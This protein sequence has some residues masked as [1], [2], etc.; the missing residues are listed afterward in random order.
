M[1]WEKVKSALD[2]L[3][4]KLDAQMCSGVAAMDATRADNIGDSM[5]H[6]QQMAEKHAAKKEEYRGA[7]QYDTLKAHDRAEGLHY[8]AA[9]LYKQ[10]RQN[11]MGQQEANKAAERANSASARLG[12]TRADAVG[13]A[14]MDASRD[15]KYD[16]GRTERT[17][18]IKKERKEFE[19]T[20]VQFS[21]GERVRFVNKGITQA[22][23]SGEQLSG[24]IT[25]IR[26]SLKMAWVKIDGGGGVFLHLHLLKK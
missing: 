23:H 25:E 10:L 17:R 5:S 2:A 6:H 15:P 11:G 16:P 26:P 21:E 18:E 14:A 24:V 9:G 19:K 3:Y 8:R 1:S 12:M 20:G 4:A 13:V 7:G 22:F